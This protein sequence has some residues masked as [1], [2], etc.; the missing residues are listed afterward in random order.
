[1]IQISQ[2][3]KALMYIR[4]VYEMREFSFSGAI[5]QKFLFARHFMF[6]MFAAMSFGICFVETCKLEKRNFVFIYA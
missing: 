5:C 2:C 6:S 1:M 3:C 4:F